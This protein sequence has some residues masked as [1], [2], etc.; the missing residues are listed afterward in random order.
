MAVADLNLG[1]RIRFY[2]ERVGCRS[3]WCRRL[4]RYE[5]LADDLVVAHAASVSQPRGM[6]DADE[7]VEERVN[8]TPDRRSWRAFARGLTRFAGGAKP[9]PGSDAWPRFV[10]DDDVA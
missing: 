8:A 6:P 5:N 10:G 2:N 1:I 7:P 9:T 4:D 3:S